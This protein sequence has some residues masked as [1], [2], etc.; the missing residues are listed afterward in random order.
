MISLSD[1]RGCQRRAS[2][3]GDVP[4]TKGLDGF[5]QAVLLLSSCTSQVRELVTELLG[6]LEICNFAV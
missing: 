3:N 1:G 2:E 6:G 4:L 5:I